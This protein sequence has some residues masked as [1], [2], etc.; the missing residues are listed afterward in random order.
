MFVLSELKDVIRIE[1][2]KFNRDT[3]EV[4]KTTLNQKY[5]NKVR[6]KNNTLFL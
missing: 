3:N 4:I 2:W 5:A 1:P 6:A